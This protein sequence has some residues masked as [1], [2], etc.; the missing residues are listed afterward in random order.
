MVIVGHGIDLESVSAIWRAYQKNPKFA[1]R[2]L[3]SD[4]LA[5]FSQLK[6]KRKQTY[7]A[8]RWSG[9]EAFAKAYG[10][11]IGLGKLRFHDLEILSR[12]TG[13]PYFSKSPFS[14]R[15]FISISH[16]GDFVQA[17]VILEEET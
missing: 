12:E 10:T 8:G 17:S 3:T 2:I 16:S 7:L 14:G 9:K 5:V 13:A 15:V 11:G 6:G 4:E 1:N